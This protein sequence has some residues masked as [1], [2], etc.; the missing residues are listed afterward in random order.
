M[1]I[2]PNHR[3]RVRRRAS[4]ASWRRGGG[5]GLLGI[6]YLALTL[7]SGCGSDERRDQYYGTDVGSGYL[8]PDAETDGGSAPETAAAPD[9]GTN[10]ADGGVDAA[11]GDPDAAAVVPPDADG[12]DGSIG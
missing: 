5:L 9:A 6:F 2:P 11:A 8:L 1:S 12:D 3:A 7:S 4:D 10:G